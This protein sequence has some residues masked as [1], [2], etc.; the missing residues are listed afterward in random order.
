MATIAAYG[1]LNV[2]AAGFFVFCLFVCLWCCVYYKRKSY[3]YIHNI[4][5][6]T[7]ENVCVCVCVFVFFSEE[8]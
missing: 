1:A 5:T 6:H 2:T 4:H 7:L 3:M 8:G